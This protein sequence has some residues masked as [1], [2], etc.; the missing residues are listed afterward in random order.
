MGEWALE[1]IGL[2][3][4]HQGV[5]AGAGGEVG[6][7]WSGGCRDRSRATSGTTVLLMMAIFTCSVEFVMM[8]NWDTS[9]EVPAVVGMQISG[10]MGTGTCPRLRSPG[11]EAAV[12]GHDA[13]ALGA[14]HGAAAAHGHDEVAAVAP[15]A[16]GPG[17]DL[18]GPGIGGDR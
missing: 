3:G 6:G 18:F 1:T 5:H 10:G 12:G 14:V 9:A 17:H 2:D 16:L 11:C 7:P 15:I 4:V 13:D 8:A